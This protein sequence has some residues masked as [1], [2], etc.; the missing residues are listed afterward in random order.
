VSKLKQAEFLKKA[1][2]CLA[3]DRY[4]TQAL[5]F[6]LADVDTGAAAYDKN[7]GLTNSQGDRKPAFDAFKKVGTL[8]GIQCGGSLDTVAPT[9]SVSSP[10]HGSRWVTY[11]PIRISARDDQR[12][13]AIRVI[14]DGKGVGL[15][16]RAKGTGA[17]VGF[18]WQ[19]AKKLAYGPHTVVITAED[20]AKN[21]ASTTIQLTKVG[22]GAYNQAIPT[23]LSLKVSAKGGRVRASGRVTP[24]DTLGRPSGY[25]RVLVQRRSGGGWKKAKRY[26]LDAK[27]SFRVSYR[28]GAGR[29]RVKATFQAKRGLPFKAS[30]ATVSPR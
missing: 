28:G 14:V 11:L 6:S 18:D 27:R 7:L 29:Y 17:S 20:E 23:K 13:R 30:E 3:N 5:W 22:G 21:L 16:T 10:R 12:V 9:L 4:V 8:G 2:G 19:G 26:V 25:I 24:Q 1:Y 15:H